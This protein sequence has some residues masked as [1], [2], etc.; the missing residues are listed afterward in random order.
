MFT[1]TTVQADIKIIKENCTK[2]VYDTDLC[3][4]AMKYKCG[5]TPHT[6]GHWLQSVDLSYLTH[7]H[8]KYS[9]RH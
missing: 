7:P 6:T 2:Y 9:P 8:M 4:A 1:Q 3:V 5:Y